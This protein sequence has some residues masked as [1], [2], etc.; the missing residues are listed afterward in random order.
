MKLRESTIVRIVA[1]QKRKKQ[2]IPRHTRTTIPH[3]HLTEG[4]DGGGGGVVGL[5][6]PHE[7]AGQLIPVLAD[8]AQ[9]LEKL[10]S[11][12]GKQLIGY[13]PCKGKCV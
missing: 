9:V 13:G 3:V 11:F 6:H 7:G 10:Q 5:K 2:S 8:V 4:Q 12:A 1:T